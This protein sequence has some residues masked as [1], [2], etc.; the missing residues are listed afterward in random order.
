MKSRILRRITAFCLAA[1]TLSVCFIPSVA[2][3]ASASF[4]DVADGKWYAK[5]VK[6][7]AENGLMTGTAAGVFSPGVHF[8]RAMT[9]QALSRLSGEDLS[10]YT[11]TDFADV[12][13]GKWYTAATAWAADKGIAAGDGVNFDPSGFVTR[14]QLALMICQFAAKYVIVND[15]AAGPENTD[16]FADA[17]EIHSWAKEGIDWAVYNGL[18]TG[19]GNGELDPTGTATR[20]Q[21]A[22][23]FHN[24]HYMKNNG[25]LPPNDSDADSFNIKESDT[26]RILCWGDS[27][28]SGGYPMDLRE[29]TGIPTRDFGIGGETA[30]HIA[31]RQGALPLYVAPVTIPAKKQA[32]DILL[33]DENGDKVHNLALFGTSGLSPVIID[34]VKGHIAYNRDTEIYSFTRLNDGEELV[35]SRLTR[36]I[37]YGMQMRQ[38]SDIHII[39]SGANNGYSSDEAHKLIDVQRRMIDYLGSDRYIII[40][41]TC[42]L[43]MPN[44]R[45]FNDDL[46]AEYGDHFLDIH[47]YFITDALKDAGIEPTEQDLID[48]E[49][50]ETPSSLRVDNDHGNSVYS[51]L[52]AEQ[53]AVKLKEL[54]FI[55]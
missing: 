4:T 40:S 55:D 44:L 17:D 13:A 18:L 8:T 51:R 22:Q 48:M 52:L 42:L 21:A 26:P 47:K 54:G 46:A 43:Y 37:T 33:I 9:V 31:M 5:A 12:P 30:E 6:Y 38:S 50:G 19:V 11:T 10:G 49:M 15:F 3:R 53:L 41:Q 20:A 16:G 14:E 32:V 1:L 45:Q 35:I 2:E 29:I 36:V 23:I 34:G 39:F 25:F 27:L 7:A 24:L 28:T